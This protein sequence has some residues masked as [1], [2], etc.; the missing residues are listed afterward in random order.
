MEESKKIHL[1]WERALTFINNYKDR[2]RVLR[3]H[4]Q[5][6]APELCSFIFPVNNIKELIHP[7]VAA[8][9][10]GIGYHTVD[11]IA[12]DGYTL[13]AFG[14]DYQDN[15]MTAVDSFVY[16][17]A[18]LATVHP[19]N[20]TMN[21]ARFAIGNYKNYGPAIPVSTTEPNVRLNGFWFSTTE[22]NVLIQ[23][24][25]CAFVECILGYHTNASM[26]NEKEGYTLIMLGNDVG[27]N[28]QIE[29]IH[30]IFDYAH[31]CPKSCPNGLL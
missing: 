22:L 29:T 5:S 12:P 1:R 9:F 11:G 6:D 15:L 20:I 17:S 3:R 26:Y 4:S 25:G 30:E 23:Q 13:I 18:L 2:S 14:V 7:D 21:A 16:D 31:P 10:F 8:V 27:G 24:H 19:S 28:R